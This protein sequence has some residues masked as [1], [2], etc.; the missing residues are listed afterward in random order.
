ML[1]LIVLAFAC[2][3][4]SEASRIGWNSNGLSNRITDGKDATPGQFPY[5][6]S[7]EWSFF[8]LIVPYRHFC[9]GSVLNESWVLTAGHCLTELPSIG[10]IRVN[11]GKFG[12]KDDGDDQQ[13]IK[14][15]KKI[16]HEQ[17][18]GGVAP[19]DIALL[20][21]RTPLVFNK[22]VGPVSL[23]EQD[24]EF[25]GEVVLSGWGSTS[26]DLTTE[27]PKVLQYAKVPLVDN[28][29]CN[30]TLQEVEL[31]V[32]LFDTQICSGPLGDSVSACSGD[33]GGPLV[34]EVDGT[35]VQ[36]G[37][38]SWGVQPC[39]NGSPSVYTRVASFVDWINEK[40]E[41]NSFYSI[42]KHSTV[43]SDYRSGIG[44]LEGLHHEV[45]L[46]WGIENLKYV[47]TKIRSDPSWWLWQSLLEIR[48]REFSC[49]QATVC[50]PYQVLKA[51]IHVL[52]HKG[53]PYV[54]RALLDNGSQVHFL[55]VRMA[56]KL[57]LSLNEIEIPRGGVNQMSSS[58][59]K[60]TR[61]TIQSRLN[62]FSK[63]LTFLITPEINPFAPSEPINR[64]EL[65]IPTNLHLA[66]PEF[67][68]PGE[69]DAL[70][71]AEIFLQL[72]CNGQITLA[73]KDAI[74]QK[75]K[76]GWILGG[77]T[78]QFRFPNAARC[79]LSLNLLNRNIE[80]FWEL[81]HCPQASRLSKEEIACEAHFE[82][83]TFRDKITGKYC[84]K[85]PFKENEPVLDKLRLGFKLPPLSNRIVGGEE[86]AEGQFPHQVS[87]Q[88]GYP[89]LSKL[90][91]FCGGTIISESWILTAGH[92]ILAI[93]SYGTFV[94]KGGKHT[95]SE[96]EETEQAIEVAKSIVHER[97]AGGVNPYDIA[98]I[99]L[100]KPL[101]LNERVNTINL[102]KANAEHNGTVILSGWGSTSNVNNA[103]MPDILQTAELPVVDLK[104]C[105]NA[106]EELTGPSPLEDT[107]IC[108]GPLTG[109]QSACSGDSGGPLI[110]KNEG[111]ESEVVGVVSWGI[112]PCGSI[113]APSVYTKV[114][115]YI[116]WI[117]SAIVRNS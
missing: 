100:K 78:S 56:S 65:K 67:Y 21:L 86:A 10:N 108:T 115:S 66:D 72:L 52:D 7:L 80:K 68:K 15:S 29:S 109:G 13:K 95:I 69:I 110:A 102:P 107:N 35:P 27:L 89:P 39:G 81:E 14:I 82:K 54:C 40:M 33:S 44:A 112:V 106:I 97:Y 62:T 6:I 19:F 57:G 75:T 103:I 23:P 91:H 22:R 101:T 51:I 73:D 63:D 24:E 12:I 96:T 9:G 50:S 17:Y 34:K 85:L 92:C 61:T 84:V 114:S 87:L 88:W 20:K 26:K 47:G 117:Q 94:V 31:G 1:K 28:D 45:Q 11:A 83:H 76:L 3:G 30:Q 8:P 111:G 71:G 53:Y 104:T 105:R 49:F 74:L 2:H 59:S 93:P 25:E 99:K 38:V 79:N 98:L 32:E 77:K 90:R 18:N 58:I 46:L 4:L 37:I 5:Q 43:L 36:V 42:V 116:G 64:S 48:G 70:I 16:V 60:I 113:G 41:E 55:T